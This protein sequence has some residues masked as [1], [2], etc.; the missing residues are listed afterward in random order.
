MSATQR[1]DP[2]LPRWRQTLQGRY[3]ALSSRDRMALLMLAVFLLLLLLWQGVWAPMRAALKDARADV[4]AEQ[5]LQVHLR[6]NA[7]RLAARGHVAG[8]VDA[9]QMPALLAAGAQKRGIAL[10]QVQPRP[11]K[12]V[13]ISLQGAPEEVVAWLGD[14]QSVGVALVEVSLLQE[15][16]GPWRG[17]VVIATP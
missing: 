10:I 17:D 8:K 14:L 12:Q 7:P 6:N 15:E 2:H 16:S 3:R 5:E 4:V 13:A 1:S 9:A 11:G